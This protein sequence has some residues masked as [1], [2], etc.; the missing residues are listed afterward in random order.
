MP[1]GMMMIVNV[2]VT[3]MITSRVLMTA[4]SVPRKELRTLGMSSSTT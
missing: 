1:S 2:G 4:K 3:I